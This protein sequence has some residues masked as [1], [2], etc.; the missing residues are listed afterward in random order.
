MDAGADYVFL[1]NQDAWVFEDTIARLIYKMEKEDSIG[2]LSPMHYDGTGENLDKGFNTYYSRTIEKTQNN[3]VSVPFVNAAA[4]MLSRKCVEKI[5]FF[6]PL[7]GHYGED[8]NY[9]DRVSYHKFL[10]GIDEDSRIVHDRVIKR[11]FNKD[12]IQSK[13][14]ILS[15]VLNINDSIAQSWTNG[16]KEALGLPKYFSKFYGTRWAVKMSFTLVA[17]YFG[18]LANSG[19]IAKARN[20]AK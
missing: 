12:V 7:Y 2:I 11:N 10:I 6:E 3:I 19:K 8:R 20:N 9:C 13:Y 1:L 17:Y 4:W 16:L 15:A 18:L 14:K 5:G